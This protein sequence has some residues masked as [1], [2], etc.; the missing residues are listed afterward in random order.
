VA[1][2]DVPLAGAEP[3]PP[4][5]HEANNSDMIKPMTMV[6]H[7]MVAPSCVHLFALPFI[8][9]PRIKL[10][11]R[12]AKKSSVTAALRTCANYVKSKLQQF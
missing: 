1:V 11:C 7:E 12:H 9:A 3:P 4:P 8:S 10:Q 5:P 6:R 2:S